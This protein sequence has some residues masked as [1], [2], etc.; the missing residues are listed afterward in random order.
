LT[1]RPRIKDTLRRLLFAQRTHSIGKLE[2]PKPCPV[3]SEAVQP[4]TLS[5]SEE[6]LDHLLPLREGEATAR[7]GATVSDNNSDSAAHMTPIISN[8]WGLL[9][10][11]DWS[12]RFE[13]R[14]G[15]TPSK[16]LKS[17]PPRS[18]TT[19]SLFKKAEPSLLLTTKT[20]A[21]WC[22]VPNT[23]PQLRSV[24]DSCRREL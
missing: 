1:N 15:M 7:L 16:F 12:G 20:R 6:D 2:N 19:P 21:G 4:R 13:H 11:S 10:G 24:H 18:I 22:G 3:W 8:L 14:K 17:R 23:S 5:A 9:T